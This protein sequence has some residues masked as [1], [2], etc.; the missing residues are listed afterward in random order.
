[1]VR[2]RQHQPLAP[3]P[4]EEA[5][6]TAKQWDYVADLQRKLLDWGF[7]W[8][9]FL[10]EHLPMVEQWYKTLEDW[11][12]AWIQLW[13]PETVTFRTRLLLNRLGVLTICLPLCDI[14][15]LAKL[16]ESTDGVPVSFKSYPWWLQKLPLVAYQDLTQFLKAAESTGTWQGAIEGNALPAA[17]QGRS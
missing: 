15:G 10:G 9:A 4:V 13:Q 7:E 12:Q 5:V 8:P 14:A 1:M 11:T 3:Q 2:S 6:E 16:E 17:S